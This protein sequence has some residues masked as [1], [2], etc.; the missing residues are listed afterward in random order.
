MLLG[1]VLESVVVEVAPQPY[2]GQHDDRPVIHPASSSLAAGLA[3]DICRNLPQNCVADL[4]W[5]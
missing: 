1:Q 4:G 3:V 5:L 2:G